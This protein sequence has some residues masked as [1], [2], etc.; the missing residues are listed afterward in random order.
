MSLTTNRDNPELNEIKEN[1]QNKTYL[2]L[3]EEEISKGFIRPVRDTYIHIGSKVV[4][5]GTI[6]SLE[7]GL[8]NLSDWNK[9]YF[10]EANGYVAYLK[11]SEEKSPLTGK[12]IKQNELDAIN[13]K[14]DYVGGCGTSTKMN[15]TIAETYA[16]DP[17]FYGATFCMGCNTHLP[18][19]E[20]VWDGTNEEVKN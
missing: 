7:F 15:I 18:V 1:G 3:S 8:K 10:T 17:K 2:V 6:E 12:F 5:E 20:F 4:R 11:Y 14:G 13:S 16:R 19:G 9:E